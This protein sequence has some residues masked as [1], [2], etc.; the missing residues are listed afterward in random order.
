MGIFNFLF[1]KDKKKTTFE[2]K[3]VIQDDSK[4]EEYT[5][6]GSN[7]KSKLLPLIE[8]FKKPKLSPKIDQ[9]SDSFFEDT[10]NQVN[11]YDTYESRL[12]SGMKLPPSLTDTLICDICTLNEGDEDFEINQI[13][14]QNIKFAFDKYLNISSDQI[15]GYRPEVHSN[16]I[17]QFHPDE[18]EL[19]ANEILHY[20][21]LNGVR[22]TDD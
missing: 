6:I 8:I 9:S 22:D 13:T 17:K 21:L 20:I 15:A 11:N 19:L 5:N 2:Q 1:G 7:V 14:I 18:L 10:I 12:A 3:E 4:T 16:F